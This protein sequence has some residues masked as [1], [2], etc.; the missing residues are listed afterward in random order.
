MSTI[1]MI[2]H[3]QAS[4]GRANYDCLSETGV[5][6]AG[7]TAKDMVRKNRRFDAIYSGTL[8]RQQK[9]AEAYTDLCSRLNI[10]T[11]RLAVSAVLDEYDSESVVTHQVPLMVEED[12]SISEDLQRIY[13]DRKA[14]QRIFE[15]AMRRWT[16]GKCDSPGGPTW[17]KFKITVISGLQAI[18][19]RHGAKKRIAV[20]T[21]GGPI[22]VAVQAAMGLTDEKTMEVSWQ[23]MN[24]SVT[25][26]RYSG[27]K[28]GLAGFNDISHLELMND[29]TL[30]TYR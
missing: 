20:F 2:R 6:Q 5:R 21:S 29:A 28:I 24:A 17:Q 1:Y 12:P 26:F 30:L 25:R 23:I 13:S 3:G 7:I 9:T 11:P 16:S 27:K 22:A 18:M 14:F 15:A 4:F 8:D 10:Q 19:E